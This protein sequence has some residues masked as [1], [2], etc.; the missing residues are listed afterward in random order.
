MD[1][2]TR[3][4]DYESKHLIMDYL[5][6]CKEGGSALLVATHDVEFASGL[7]DRVAIMGDGGMITDG[8]AAEVMSDSLF[9]SPQVNRLLGGYRQGVIR[10]EDAVA[11]LREVRPRCD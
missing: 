6:E 1:E 8:P 10:E 7:S 11:I 2:P 9:F 4:L 5:R 3:G